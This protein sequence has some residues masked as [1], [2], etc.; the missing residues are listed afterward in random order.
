M[1]DYVDEIF[2]KGMKIDAACRKYA[3]ENKIAR[4][5]I[6]C[7]ICERPREYYIA[8]NNH[9]HSDCECLSVNQ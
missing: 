5:E 8:R 6:I 1:N 2:K 4:G 9:L 7:P 3:E